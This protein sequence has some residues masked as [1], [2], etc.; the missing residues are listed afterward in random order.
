MFVFPSRTDT[1][2][3]VM[4]EALACGVPVAAYPVAGPIDVINGHRV[5]VLDNDLAKA[6]RAALEIPA[7]ACRDFA[8]G[9]SWRAS[10]EQ[11]FSNL[12]PFRTR[13]AAQAA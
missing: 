5:G 1:F 8:M 10:A 6:T 11:F 9:M 4:L 2:G 3:N 7:Q 12:A 13:G